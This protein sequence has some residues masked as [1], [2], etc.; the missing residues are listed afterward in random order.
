MNTNSGLS[1]A[2]RIV[3][4]F[5]LGVVVFAFVAGCVAQGHG[6]ALAESQLYGQADAGTWLTTVAY[7]HSSNGI[8]WHPLT[9]DAAI[10]LLALSFGAMTAFNLAIARH[11][12][13]VADPSIKIV[14]P[15]SILLGPHINA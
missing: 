14:K 9:R 3:F 11:L 15:P 8:G 12:K 5:G 13:A 10:M 6:P 1:A 2:A 4:D 7:A